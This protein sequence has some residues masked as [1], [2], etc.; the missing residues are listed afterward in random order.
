MVRLSDAASGASVP[1]RI[2][3]EQ[4]WSSLPFLGD[5]QF[6]IRD[7][8][9]P[10]VSDRWIPAR[11]HDGH[12]VG[13]AETFEIVLN[14]LNED[15]FWCRLEANRLTLHVG[16]GVVYLG[17]LDEIPV[18]QSAMRRGLVLEAVTD[19][20][21]SIERISPHPY[22]VVDQGF[23]TDV[24]RRLGDAGHLVML[25]QWAGGLG[26]EIWYNIKSPNDIDYIKENLIP[27]SICAVFAS[28]RLIEIS[29]HDT[30]LLESVIANDPLYGNLRLLES[31]NSNLHPKVSVVANATTLRTKWQ[32]LS[33]RSTLLSWPD[34]SDEGLTFAACPDEDG[35]VR[36]SAVFD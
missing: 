18:V 17:T 1:M 13:T 21:Y 6:T 22:R 24:R 16:E 4:L 30:E 19:S 3:L 2:L 9:V 26:G 20:P 27:R 11:C 5:E 23:W 15:G 32:H 34:E 12:R 8:E 36:T 35:V 29:D 31:I 10:R 25:C 14:M 28:C 7:P 33:P